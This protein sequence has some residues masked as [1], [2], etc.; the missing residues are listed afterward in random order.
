MGS[1]EIPVRC[2]CHN[3]RSKKVHLQSHSSKCAQHVLLKLDNTYLFTKEVWRLFEW[4]IYIQLPGPSKR[5]SKLNIP[6]YISISLENVWWRPSSIVYYQHKYLYPFLAYIQKCTNLLVYILWVPFLSLCHHIDVLI[7]EINR[8]TKQQK[9]QTEV[10]HRLSVCF[11][12]RPFMFY[13]RTIRTWTFEAE[14]NQRAIQTME[15]VSQLWEGLTS[16]FGKKTR[17]SHPE[18]CSHLLL[19]VSARGKINEDHLFGAAMTL[20]TQ[21]RRTMLA[22]CAVSGRF[23]WRFVDHVGLTLMDFCFSYTDPLEL[24]VCERT[25]VCV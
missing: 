6:P 16:S 8:K 21:R 14:L 10:N 22:M 7:V 25:C 4:L 9:F 11:L 2:R 17:K 13:T 12:A 19:F 23:T 24:C 18:R 20:K 15:N 3:T 5:S 1:D